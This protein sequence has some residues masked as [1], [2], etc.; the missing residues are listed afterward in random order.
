LELTPEEFEFTSFQS[1]DS[2]A[3]TNSAM[4]V[5]Y[6]FRNISL[7]LFLNDNLAITGNVKLSK[8]SLSPS[9]NHNIVSTLLPLR[10][11]L[12]VESD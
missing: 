2:F 6:H 7:L 1:L 8:E 10:T 5:N 9:D 12:N 4:T 3:R 11:S